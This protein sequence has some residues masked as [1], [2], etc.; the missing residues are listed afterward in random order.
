V[1]KRKPDA[2]QRRREL[3]DA[4]IL[5]LSEDGARGLT[6]RKVEQCAGLPDGTTSSYFPTRTALLHAVARRV[7]ELDGADFTAALPTGAEGGSG[8]LSQI[9]QM[10]MRSATE[11]GLSRTR[12]R[13]E[14]VLN[15]RRDPRLRSILD[16]A[17]EGFVVL[18]ER[19]LIRL[20]PA[21]DVDTELVEAQAYVL[22]TFINGIMM[23]LALGDSAVDTVEALEHLLHAIVAGV[24]ATRPAPFTTP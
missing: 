15:A 3:C 2:E 14:L 8:S 23:R 17:I 18:S 10:V 24:A 16:G 5:V 6:H 7:A 11:P 1:N 20:Q 9:A 12:A 13:Y 19:A 4:A 21:D 22:T